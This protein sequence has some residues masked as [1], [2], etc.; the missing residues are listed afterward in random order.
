MALLSTDLRTGTKDRRLI[1]VTAVTTMAAA[2][3]SF[4][5]IGPSWE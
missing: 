1:T 4:L 2:Q 5:V 3:I